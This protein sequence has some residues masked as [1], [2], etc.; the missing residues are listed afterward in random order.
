MLVGSF[1][2]I[3]RDVWEI[4]ESQQWS[5][6][7]TSYIK[8]T[9]REQ[10]D[11]SEADFFFW[12]KERRPLRRSRPPALTAAVAACET[13]LKGLFTG[14]LRLSQDADPDHPWTRAAVS[15]WTALL[16]PGAELRGIRRSVA[17]S[18]ISRKAPLTY[19]TP[20]TPGAAS[21][22]CQSRW[23]C[24]VALAQGTGES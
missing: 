24:G 5:Y 21:S 9:F 7:I 1:N 22:S 19:L 8:T 4:P 2:A 18:H 13:S 11:N 16:G 12:S 6:F 14:V 20:Q 23:L 3:F 17:L 15:S 10:N